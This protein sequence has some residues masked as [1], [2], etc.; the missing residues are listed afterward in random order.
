MPR[1]SA[2]TLLQRAI[3][4]AIEDRRALVDAYGGVGPDAQAASEEAEAFAGLRGRRIRDLGPEECERAFM[5]FVYAEQY[6]SSLAHASVTK[7][8]VRSS[9][10][11]AKRFRE[12][13]VALWGRTRQ[14]VF[15]ASAVCVDPMEY[16]KSRNASGTELTQ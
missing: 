11:E 2:D 3:H 16:M 6:E 5:A 14:E 8:L 12:A 4:P 9:L 1:L 10:L 13:R 15:L 7:G